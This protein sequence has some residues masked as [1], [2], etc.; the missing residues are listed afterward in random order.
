MP[1]LKETTEEMPVTYQITVPQIKKWNKD[2]GEWELL[3]PY[4]PPA[5]VKYHDKLRI[6]EGRGQT[7]DIGIA[8]ELVEMGA[9]VTPDPRPLWQEEYAQE[10]E[11]AAGTNMSRLQELAKY[12]NTTNEWRAEHHVAP[13][14]VTA[15]NV[16][17]AVSALLTA[18]QQG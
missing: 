16:P 6:M 11:R 13:L 2:N 17:L 8:L 12:V 15:P 1:K 14:S 5:W 4:T 18:V 7:D 3:P 9:E 10:L